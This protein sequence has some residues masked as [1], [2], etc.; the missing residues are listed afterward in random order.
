[1]GGIQ[2]AQTAPKINHLLFADDCFLF[3][4]ASAREAASLKIVLQKYCDAS[5]QRTNNAKSSIY[6]GKK[7]SAAIRLE[8]MRTLDVQHVTLN[9]KYLGLPSDV[10]RSKNG[11]FSYLRHRV[12]KRLQG[13]MKKILSGGGRKY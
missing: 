9:E 12:W 3:C 7:V 10:G 13:W 6:F 11:A 1:L 2:V 8:M 5:G 4:K